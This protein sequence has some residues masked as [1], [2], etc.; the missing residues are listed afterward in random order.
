M[1]S[2]KKQHRN[3]LLAVNIFI[4]VVALVVIAGFVLSPDEPEPIQGQVEV[5][6]Y[7]VSSK[8][9]GRIL[10][11]RV[12]EGDH[13][14]A[15]DT[16]AILSA[17]DIE[18]RL[19][20]AEEAREAASAV[21]QK[22]RNGAREEQIRGA[23]EQWQQAKAGREIAEK[24]YQRVEHLFQ[25]GV[26][27]EQKRDEARANYKAA[28]A[29]EKAAQSQYDM[30][31]NGAREEDQRAA[32]AQTERAR[33]AVSEVNSYLG[34]TVQMAQMA[35]E[36]SSVYPKVGELVG[37]GSPIMTIAVLDDVWATFNVREDRLTHLRMGDEFTA[38]IPT[39]ARDI[40][41]KVFYIK[42]QGSYAVWKATKANGG[43][44]LRTFEVKARPMEQVEG[45]RP[46]MSIIIK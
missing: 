30:A 5:T 43:Y 24:S 18:A 26:M 45:L 27:S 41:M 32:A 6:E 42:P 14:E 37:T 19:A 2:T 40:R 17:P 21:E 13:V 7:R 1:L 3:I 33:G 31:V 35:G 9:P 15:G 38:Y 28:E 22:A 20:Q 34:E 44:D 36:V 16:L 12:S 29:R 4:V 39:F 23:Y 8:V 11:L 10:E 25:E 46:G